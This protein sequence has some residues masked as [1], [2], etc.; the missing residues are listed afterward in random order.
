[1]QAGSIKLGKSRV[2]GKKKKKK[3]K[4]NLAFF[5]SSISEFGEILEADF[6]ELSLQ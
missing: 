3:L 4:E 6:Q 5:G 2:G 1:M